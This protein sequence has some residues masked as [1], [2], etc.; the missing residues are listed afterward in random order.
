MTTYIIRRLMVMPII[1][2][3]VTMLIF[4]MLQV[5]GPVERSALY[6]RD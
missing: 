4:A 5:L 6:V 3:G 1:L 2:I